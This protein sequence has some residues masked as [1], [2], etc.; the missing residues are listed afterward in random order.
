VVGARLN[1]YP[2]ADPMDGVAHRASLVILVSKIAGDVGESVRKL[3]RER[4]QIQA[5]RIVAGAALRYRALAALFPHERDLLILDATG[6]AA[7]LSLVRG[8]TL[9]A[10]HEFNV[11]G[12]E[13]WAGA[14]EGALRDLA[15][16]YPLPRT[17]LLAAEG[18]AAAKRQT[19]LETSGIGALWFAETPPRIIAVPRVAAGAVALAP[20][21]LPDMRLALAA[22]AAALPEYE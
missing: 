8:K 4:F 19:A 18:D 1:G 14:T 15:A 6:S 10:L 3:A 7:A 5:P 17:I 13:A 16:K 22:F 20:Q 12:G 2:T 9:V 21:A 11:G